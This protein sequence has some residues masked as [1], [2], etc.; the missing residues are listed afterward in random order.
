MKIAVYSG[1]FNPLHIGHL[2]IMEHLTLRM[3]FDEVYLVVSPKNPLKDDISAISGEARY[4]AACEAISRHPSLRVRADAIELG[5]RPPY[6]TVRTLQALSRREPGN[7]FTLVIG[8]DQLADFRRWKDYGRILRDY[9]IVVFPREGFDS[10]ADA[11]SLLSEDSSYKI[12]LADFPLVDVSSTQI[13]DML[14]RGED[15]T[16]LLM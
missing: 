15:V 8:G 12:R 7:A 3:D 10:A 2:A 9:G 6:Y 5:M 1:S 13:R 11:A 16:G 4:E 14:S